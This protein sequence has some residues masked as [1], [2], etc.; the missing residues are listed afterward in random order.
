MHDEITCIACGALVEAGIDCRAEN[1]PGDPDQWALRHFMNPNRAYNLRSPVDRFAIRGSVEHKIR[2]CNQYL[3]L[4][5]V[6]HPERPDVR[7]RRAA[8]EAAL[9]VLDKYE[10]PATR[11]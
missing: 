1:C 10:P 2:A 4:L 6:G 9:D 5:S 3:A 8:C 11:L 7:A